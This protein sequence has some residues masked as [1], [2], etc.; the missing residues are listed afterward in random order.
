MFHMAF[1]GSSAVIGLGGYW[2]YKRKLAALSGPDLSIYD[3]DRP[4]DFPVDPKTKGLAE[5]NQ[6]L[7]DKFIVPAQSPEGRNRKIQD[8][9]RFFEAGGLE[10]SDPD[11]EYRPATYNVDGVT[12]TGVWTLVDGYDSTKRILYLHGGG[13]T[14]GSDISHRP[15]TTNL[16]KRTKAAVFVPNYRLMPENP[17]KASVEDCRAAYPWILENGPDGPE[18]C[19]SLAVAGDSAGGNLTLMIANWV[20]ETDLRKP[21]AIYVLSPAT[22]STA[23]S[24]SIRENFETDLMLQPLIKPFLKLPRLMLLLGL[25]KMSGYH[26]TNPDISPIHDNLSNLPPTLIQVSASEMLYDDAVRYANKMEEAGS[27]VILQSWDHVPHVF[28]MF[29][30]Y[31]QAASEALDEAGTFLNTHLK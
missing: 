15:L 5:L 11:T 14:V 9:R 20:R 30:N 6:Y 19:R 23:E 13:G 24:P 2:L 8:K 1:L 3:A 12:I 22:D 27:P 29:D 28:Q 16:A 31:I 7:I 10:R 4:V 25:K 18:A 26:P 17:R 21:D